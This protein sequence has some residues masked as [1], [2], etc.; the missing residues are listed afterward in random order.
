MLGDNYAGNDLSESYQFLGDPEGIETGQDISGTAPPGSD[1]VGAVVSQP[2]LYIGQKVEG[3]QGKVRISVS[4]LS[5]DGAAVAV[6][7][8][9]AVTLEG[10]GGQNL[11]LM[12]GAGSEAPTAGR[13]LA[14]YFEAP[15]GAFY[16]LVNVDGEGTVYLDN[17]MICPAEEDTC[18]DV[19]NNP[20]GLMGVLN[21]DP[22]AGDLS[23]GVSDG[24]LL[25][26]NNDAEGENGFNAPEANADANNFATAG[27]AGSISLP[28][29]ADGLSNFSVFVSGFQA[30]GML[31]VNCFAQNATGAGADTF[32][33]L[34][35][36]AS[37]VNPQAGD[38]AFFTTFISGDNISSGWDEVSTFGA[39]QDGASGVLLTVQNAGNGTI[40]VDD[41]S[42]YPVLGTLTT[43]DAT[44]LGS[45]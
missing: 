40:N 38:L 2:G 43:F 19:T 44:S 7:A 9:D 15:S 11:A 36:S 23:G 8:M 17:L 10:T 4:A 26:L 29:N 18:Y 34:V 37:G 33:A 42:A 12:S 28:A 24:M 30:P 35:V 32:L 14:T 21:T 39:I 31:E 41:L 20:L 1:G 13:V 3:V 5:P 6:G 45:M 25:D 22:I 16:P 27:A